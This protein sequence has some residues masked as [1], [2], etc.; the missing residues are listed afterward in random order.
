MSE[1]I[2]E[3]KEYVIKYY[4]DT[5]FTIDIECQTILNQR[6]RERLDNS[7]LENIYINEFIGRLRIIEDRSMKKLNG[8]IASEGKNIESFQSKE[9]I[10][11]QADLESIVYIKPTDLD[12]NND[13]WNRQ[14]IGVL[15]HF[16]FWLN[17]MQSGFV[18][19]YLQNVVFGDSN[20]NDLYNFIIDKVGL[21]YESLYIITFFFQ[22]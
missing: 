19:L 7:I 9:E 18:L 20:K 16:P 12:Q 3:V 1:I 2:G 10:L 6:K 11:S 5:Q 22:Q 21:Y 17:Q 14:I 4:E 15:F 8:F 13:K